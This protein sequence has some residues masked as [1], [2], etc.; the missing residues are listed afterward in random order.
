[1]DQVIKND[2]RILWGALYVNDIKVIDE[3][4]NIDAPITTTNITASGNTTIGDAAGDT[5]TINALTTVATTQKIQ[6]RDTGIYINS[7][8]D[9]KLTIAADGA[10]TDD[11]TLSGTITLDDDLITP[12]TKK[13]QFRDS[14]LY[15][16]SKDDG[17]LDIDADISV[18]INS[19]LLNIP[20]A[21]T[22]AGV[23]TWANGIVLKNLKNSAASALSGTQLDIQID[24][25]G[26]PY[27]FTV[28]PTKA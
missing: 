8:A 7:W 1:M 13:V 25:G 23:G 24:I 5:L 26:T 12:T 9:G 15:I 19:P 21:G 17:H 27:Y 28:Y 10:G 16:S 22:I 6:F 11:I 2:L 4:G 3:N 20:S 14:A 18:D